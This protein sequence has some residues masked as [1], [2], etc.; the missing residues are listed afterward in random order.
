MKN[1][2]EL[3][4]TV[5]A[6]FFCTGLFAQTPYKTD[7]KLQM[8]AATLNLRITQNKDVPVILNVGTEG[9]IKGRCD[10]REKRL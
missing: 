8:T 9:K 6:I 7:K 3:S 2:I 5:F 1:R 4:L 10:D